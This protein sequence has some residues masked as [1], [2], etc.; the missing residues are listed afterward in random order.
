MS[1]VNNSLKFTISALAL[2]F[3]ER[4]TKVREDFLDYVRTFA[5]TLLSLMFDI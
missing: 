2:S 1:I 5:R 3:R 4:L